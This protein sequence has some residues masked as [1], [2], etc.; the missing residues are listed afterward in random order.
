MKKLI[1]LIG[2]FTLLSA[3]GDEKVTVSSS[4]KVKETKNQSTEQN[5]TI[6]EI[7][8][9]AKLE[10][11]KSVD[12]VWV[13]SIGTVWVHTAALYENTGDIP[14]EIG[15]TQMNYKAT[16]DSILGTSTMIYSVPSVVKPG[17]TAIIVESTILDGQNTA[18]SFKETTFNFNF[19][20]STNDPNLMEVSG[21]KAIPGEYGFKVT[22][23]VKNPTDSQQEDIRLAAALLDVDGNLLGALSGSVD[24][25]LATGGEAGFELSYPEVPKNIIDKISTIEVKS[26]GWTW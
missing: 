18:D 1:I 20:K 16:D 5:N 21:V 22:G 19:E 25:G 9:E 24:V 6:E 15:E 10:V 4:E 13:D 12:E 8:E 11:L 14:V 17:E 23:V 3:C 2:I 7:D 26:Y